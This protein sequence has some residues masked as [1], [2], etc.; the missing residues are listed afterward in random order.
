VKRRT[1]VLANNVYDLLVIG[2]GVVGAAVAWDAALRGFT[3]ALAEKGDFG[4]RTSANSL[5]VVHGGLRYLQELDVARVRQSVRERRAL[6]RIAPHLVRPLPCLL[7]AYRRPGPRHRAPL[8]AALRLNDLLSW[9]RNRGLSD[10]AQRLPA[11]RLISRAECLRL[12]PGVREKG[13]TG[14]ALWHDAHMANP[15]R[16]TLSFLIS[17]ARA[18]A[19]VFNHMEFLGF[20]REGD[21]VTG[22]RL[23]DASARRTLFARAKVTVNAAGPWA[24]R[25]LEG[26][27][28]V[29]P[30]RIPL[31]RAMN[32][33]LRRPLARRFAAGVYRPGGQVLFLVPWKGATL[34]GTWHTPCGGG[35]EDERPTEAEI[36]G[37]LAELN[38]AYPGA[39]LSRADVGAVFGGLLPG[40]TAE[41]GDVRLRAQ[42]LIVDHRAEDGVNGLL[43]AVGVKYT[44]ARLAAE[45]AVDE[46]VRKMGRPH[47]PC[48]TH[49]TP[50]AGGYIDRLEDYVD[51]Q[52]ALNPGL[53][54]GT[55][56]RLV[57]TYGCEYRAVLR[58]SD[59]RF[60]PGG[61]G[62]LEAEVEHAVREEMA[63][64]LA[65]AVLRR[66]EL[67]ATGHPGAACLESCA[68]LMAAALGWDGDRRRRELEDCEAQLAARLG[69]D[70]PGLSAAA[71]AAWRP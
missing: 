17:A 26:L 23:R 19:D 5:R 50:L 69:A 34:A 15:E 49:D 38:R 70:R 57:R 25:A 14:A 41:G 16:L 39:Q 56:D 11:G 4:A 31:T 21:R 7:P 47:A 53:P 55:V 24:A 61:A 20:L 43:T 46:A 66:T 60:L 67:A 10:P 45:R 37:F 9:D 29:P 54:A 33:L 13:L 6:M 51:A 32:L 65:D 40:E 30:R 18:G 52:T 59:G 8:A 3:V 71:A 62:V 28:G 36:G 58:G 68:G 2:G 42:P 35:P 12:L 44:T 64:T 22:A 27:H 1:D 63:L 48:R